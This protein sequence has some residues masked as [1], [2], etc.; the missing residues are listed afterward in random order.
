M[1]LGD[2]RQNEGLAWV[3]ILENIV[4]VVDASKMNAA[5]N[6][7]WATAISRCLCTLLDEPSCT[8][9]MFIASVPVALRL[10]LLPC[11]PTAHVAQYLA[12][13]LTW[14]RS[15]E[16]DI[17]IP[18]LPP[19]PNS[20]PTNQKSVPPHAG[21]GLWE[22]PERETWLVWGECVEDLWRVTMTLPARGDTGER[23]MGVWGELTAR[24]LVWRA[25]VGREGSEVGEWARQQVLL[26]LSDSGGAIGHDC[27]HGMWYELDY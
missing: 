9:Q 8:I 11:P 4:S 15:F 19:V 1:Q 7:E 3:K 18:I 2:V 14:L 22:M 16:A 13:S 6:G 24:I 25:L 10:S 23:I 12:C 21:H 26:N 17:D 27:M 5:T 20:Q